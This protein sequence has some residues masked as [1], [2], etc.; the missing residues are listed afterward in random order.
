MKKPVEENCDQTLV[1]FLFRLYPSPFCCQETE[2]FPSPLLC[3]LSGMLADSLSF[4]LHHFTTGCVWS[5]RDVGFNLTK[6][7]FNF[8]Q[9]GW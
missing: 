9:P 5:S 3:V 6:V 2:F 4:Y 7:L 8:R 1:F